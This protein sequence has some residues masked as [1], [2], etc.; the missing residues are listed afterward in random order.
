MPELW[1]PVRE[2]EGLYEVSDLGRVR[3]VERFV[4]TKGNGKA[5]KSSKVIAPHKHSNGYPVVNLWQHNKSKR[6]YVHRLVAQCF[7]SGDQSLT[8][9][10]IDGDK[11]NNNAINLEWISKADNT[12][13]QWSTGLASTKGWFKPKA[14]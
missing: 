13:H 2:H 10:H 7:V 6:Q 11:W 8:V 1:L 3:S 4:K 14:A 5:K 12:R 9:N